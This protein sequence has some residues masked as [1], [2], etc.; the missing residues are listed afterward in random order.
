MPPDTSLGPI[1]NRILFENDRVRVWSV[2]LAPGER[3]AWHRHDLPYLIV[4]LTEGKN[5]MTFADGRV[6]ETA[7]TPGA[8]LWR[9]PGIPHELENVGDWPYRNVLIEVKGTPAN[10]DP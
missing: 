9:E 8:A 5:V 7:E 3:Q 10:G 6:R 4:P 1:G 2:E